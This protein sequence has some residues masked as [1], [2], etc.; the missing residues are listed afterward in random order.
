MDAIREPINP[1]SH[2]L[3]EISFLIRL[4]DAILEPI[5]PNS[6]WLNEISFLIR[7]MVAIREPINP[8]SYWLNEISFLI[9]L[10]VAIREP[11]NP[12]SYW[13]NEI[14]FLIRLMVAIREPINPN[15]YWL[16]EPRLIKAAGYPVER[17]K[18]ITDD[19]YILQLYRIPGGRR[20][21]QTLDN[22]SRR[23]K[24]PVLFVHG[25]FGCSS[26]F[27]LMGPG[28]SLG[29]ILADTG[30]DVWL[31]NL[32][33]T[34]NTGHLN[35][36]REDPKFWDFSFH[37]NGKYDVPALIDK[38]LSITG[39]SKLMYIG[40]SMGTTSFF[41][42]MAL[43]PEYND[44]VF[45]SIA[46]APAVYIDNMKALAELALKTV[47]ISNWL[48]SQGMMS[49]SWNPGLLNVLT[50]T[51]CSIKQSSVNICIQLIQ[52]LFGEDYEQVDPDVVPL[53]LFRL[54]PASLRQLDH[55]GKIAMTG[56]FTSW[57]DGMLGLVKPYNLSNVRVP[58]SLLYGENDQLTQKSQ[59]MR[60]AREFNSTGMLE[61]VRPG[62]TWP[63]FNHVDFLFAKDV[64][65]LFNEPL[66]K[67]I[68]T[69]FDKYGK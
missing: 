25:L 60:L 23:D 47:K 29:Y 8:N 44:K 18:A 65:T 50:N 58:V 54:Q 52:A 12:N 11:I 64:A 63:K 37:E 24:K 59:V 53:V 39:Q 16:N 5:N 45:T 21:N 66:V 2:Q 33:G 62:C 68:Q 38:V 41:I 28:K 57:E 31:G 35:H 32:R 1:N 55:F 6:Y 34:W 36:S 67:Y 22:Y 19:G 40:H 17:H 69:L 49:V 48:R 7:L 27:I 9:R 56:V 42:A 61:E 15:S 4:M 43:R 14:S 26:N 51:L 3:N 20:Y 46:L 13:L 30:Y 10:M